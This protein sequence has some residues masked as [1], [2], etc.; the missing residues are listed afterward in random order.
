MK[1]AVATDDQKTVCPHFGRATHYLV[2]T[3]DRTT[4]VNTESRP[5]AG[6]HTASHDHAHDHDHSQDHQ[7]GHGH[8]EGADE[9]HR[10]MVSAI[11]DCPVVIVGGMGGGAQAAMRQAGITPCSTKISD[12]VQAVHAYLAGDGLFEPSCP[13]TTDSSRS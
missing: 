11:Q 10:Q 2:F 7:E 4:I 12:A 3:L 13:G 6:H 1:I 8:H 9:R 5:K